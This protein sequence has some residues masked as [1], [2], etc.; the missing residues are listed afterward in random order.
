[1]RIVKKDRQ[2]LEVRVMCDPRPIFVTGFTIIVRTR[3]RW[4]RHLVS[5]AL[6]YF[7]SVVIICVS[8]HPCAGTTMHC[9]PRDE[10]KTHVAY[11][12]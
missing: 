8:E 11:L 4:W 6:E 3:G 9:P 5:V 2:D 10:C 12:C 1:M 7:L